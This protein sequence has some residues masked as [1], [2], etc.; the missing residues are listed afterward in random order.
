MMNTCHCTIV[1]TIIWT[2]DDYDVTLGSTVATCATLVGDIDNGGYATVKAG[3]YGKFL[4]LPL[5]FAINLKVL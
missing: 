4:H 1:Q 2:L 3:I 5:N